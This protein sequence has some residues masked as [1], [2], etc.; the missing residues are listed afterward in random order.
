MALAVRDLLA[1]VTTESE[2]SRGKEDG[3][4]TRY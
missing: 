3:C 1:L 4:E 2:S